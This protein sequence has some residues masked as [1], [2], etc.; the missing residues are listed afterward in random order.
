MEKTS[1]VHKFE[2]VAVMMNVYSNNFFHQLVELVPAFL[3]LLPLLRVNPEIP[4]LMN[5]E[6]HSPEL[7]RYVGLDE[8]KLNI[9][10][11]RRDDS[12][13]FYYGRR[14]FF[15]LFPPC[16]YTTK[17]Q[18]ASIRK[19]FFSRTGSEILGEPLPTLPPLKD[20]VVV[21]LDRGTKSSGAERAL[22]RQAD[23]LERIKKEIKPAELEVFKGA[24]LQEAIRI[25]ARAHIVVGVHGAGLSNMAFL[26]QSS[27][28]VEIQPDE[29]TNYCFYNL[30]RT[31]G[32]QHLVVPA[33]GTKESPTK[34][35]PD[36]L[37]D[38]LRMAVRILESSDDGSLA[39]L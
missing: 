6:I 24:P 37:I 34:V 12:N 2:E 16:H 30:A 1:I 9:V 35:D 5:K 21:F 33:K 15:P 25:F 13:I 10:F 4:I 17:S 22:L 31:L 36:L 14:V 32:I 38:S 18:W 27:V 26:P 29:Y 20:L 23:I 8:R 19:E 11:A 7:L 3:Q 28:V 39:A